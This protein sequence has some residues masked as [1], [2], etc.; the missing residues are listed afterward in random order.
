MCCGEGCVPL[1]A[2]MGY[3]NNS[4]FDSLLPFILPSSLSAEGLTCTF[5]FFHLA[6]FECGRFCNVRDG[7]ISHLKSMCQVSLRYAA[8]N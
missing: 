6:T 7:L 1:V 8:I 5:F 3:R 4:V 2:Q